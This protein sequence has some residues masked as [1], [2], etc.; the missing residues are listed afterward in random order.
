LAPVFAAQVVASVVI[1]AADNPSNRSTLVAA[2]IHAS[3]NVAFGAR[4]FTTADQRWVAGPTDRPPSIAVTHSN[5]GVV[6]SPWHRWPREAFL[7]VVAD[8]RQVAGTNGDIDA[9]GD[10]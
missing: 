4:R 10:T 6:R 5:G 8:G 9:L 3:G 7:M 1:S 2:L